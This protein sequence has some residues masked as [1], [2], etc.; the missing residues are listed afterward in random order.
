M[1]S[2]VT[3]AYIADQRIATA[4]PTE[5]KGEFIMRIFITG[6]TGFIGSRIVPE[7][8]QAGH[9]VLGLTRSDAGAKALTAAG[10]EV[11]RGDIE[12]L[13]SLRSGSARSDGVIHTAFDHN[14]ANFVANCQKDRR[15]IEALGSALEGS[16]RQIVITSSTAMGAAVPGQPATEDYFN[17]DHPNPR[18]ASELAGLELSKRGVD[19]SVVRLSQIHNTVKQGLVTDV[20]ELA[21]RKGVSAYIGDGLNRWSATHVSD[22]ARLF[23]LAFEKH[24]AGAVGDRLDVPVI[25]VAP[26]EAAGHFGWLTAFVGKDMSASSIATKSRLGWHPTGPGLLADLAQLEHAEA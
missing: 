2:I 15:A 3:S 18:V 6:A 12:D 24:T 5:L 17:P 21:R 23:R 11:H 19:V 26:D 14:F 22:A 7:L 9:Q 13:A 10:A 4:V 20:I 16:N 25:A 1:V 8:I